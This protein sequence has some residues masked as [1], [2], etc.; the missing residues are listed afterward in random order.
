MKK[1]R[2]SGGEIA[3]NIINGFFMVIFAFVCLYPFINILAYSL[4]DALDSNLGG[5]YF[6]PRK[7]TF[8]SYIV[9]FSNRNL[10][11]AF[12]VSVARTV[13]GSLSVLFCSSMFAYTFTKRKF[14]IYKV[15]KFIFFA[16]MFIGTGA[17]IPKYMLFRS[18]GLLN[19]FL[20][21]IIPNL[22]NLW[23][24]ILFRTYFETIPNELE[25]ACNIDG[26]NDI[27]IFFRI[28]LPLS[29]PMIAT[30]GLFSMVSQWNSWQDTLFFANKQKLKTLQFMMQEILLRAEASKMLTDAGLV[31]QRIAKASTTDPK[32]IRMAI[33]VVATLPIVMVYPFL[34]KYFI[35]GM[36]VGSLKG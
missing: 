19:N 32:S 33:T 34:Q 23:Y 27:Q 11:H 18:L 10:L 3:F 8:D 21:Y 17:L 13:L 16:A 20:V 9:V 31:N 15:Q 24:V 30:V 2:Q 36:L 25:E 6:W 1:R 22:L 14:C 4:N 28:M 5:I 12:Y 7:F 35:K 29:V 26:A